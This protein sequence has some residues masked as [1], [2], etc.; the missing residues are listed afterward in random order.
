MP[1]VAGSRLHSYE[2][3]GHLGSGGMGEVFRA[4]D[5]TLKREVAIKVLPDYWSRDPERLRRFEHEAQAA[6]SLNHPNIMSIFHVGEFE[7]APYMVTELLQGETLRARLDHGRLRLR[8]SIELACQVAYGL[9]AAHS[10]GITHRDLKPDNLFVSKDGRIKILDFGLAKLQDTKARSAV[11]ETATYREDTDPGQVLGTVGYMSPEQVRGEPADTRSDIFALG[12]VL[13]EMLTGK[14]AFRKPT[15]AET[16]AAILNEEPPPISQVS[17]SVP[18]GIQRVLSRCLSKNPDQRFQHA[19]DLAFALE[20]LSDS[21]SAQAGPMKAAGLT[22]KQWIRI[23]MAATVLALA[24]FLSLIFSRL[25]AIPVVEAVSQLTDDGQPKPIWSYLATDGPRVYF[26]EG[27]TG[28][29]KIAQ[30]AATG[31]ATALITTKLENPQL[32]GIAPDGSSLLAIATGYGEAGYPLWQIPLPT[33]DARRLDQIQARDATFSPDGH[34]AFAYGHGLY[35]ARDD[36]S[37][38]RPLLSVNGLIREPSYSPDGKKLVFSSYSPSGI[39]LSI[40]EANADGSA[41]HSI[42]ESD[43]AGSVCCTQWTPDGRYIVFRKMHSGRQD[44]WLLEMKAGIFHRS[45]RTIQ[46]TNGPLSYHQG[47]VP[48]RD[49]RQI[50]AIG[51]KQRG[52][53]V[54]YDRSSKQFVPY[55]SGISVLDPTFS[56]DGTWVAYL[57]YPDHKLWRSHIDGSDRLQLTYGP[58]DIRNP[59]I[60]P[61]GKFIVYGSFRNTGR[62]LYVISADGGSPQTIVDRDSAAADWSPDGK[63]LAFAD[64]TD[65]SHTKLDLL[66]VDTKKVSVIPESE[67]LF[68]V[69]WVGANSLVAAREDYKGLLVFDVP[70]Q[71]WSN[72]VSDFIVNWAHSL[73]DEFVYYTTGGTHPKIKRVRLQGHNQPEDVA[74]LNLPRALGSGGYTY[75]SVAPDGSPVFTRD[76][77]TQEIYALKV[78]WP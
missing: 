58:E 40:T 28:S 47:A 45:H 61:D 12:V 64:G 75:L 9:A 41:P 10:A 60:S 1:L 78:K 63:L 32:V 66:E 65:G 6:A 77:G 49:G 4:R 29:L 50:F 20:S 24:A 33:G 70:G 44:L 48:S 16:L 62:V 11:A 39:P 55:L 2:I 17:T 53:L 43:A 5:L 52:E 15:S 67:G 42:V 71:R 76:I 21:S 3:L 27:P 68:A 54:R 37:D 69:G 7:G 73:D 14:R 25:S 26:N 46:L 30:V 51:T 8:E 56:K 22:G 35:L 18:P 59:R 57:S 38:S 36:G 13:Y 74:D 19:S 23:T 34:I 72:L 31:G